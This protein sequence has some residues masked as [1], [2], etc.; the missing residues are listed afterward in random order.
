MEIP[1][2]GHY[3]SSTLMLFPRQEKA[4]DQLL[5]E[6]RHKVPATLVI[7]TSRDGQFIS[8]VGENVGKVDLVALGSLI[9]GDLA[10]SQQVARLVGAFEEFQVILREGRDSRIL[11]ADAGRSMVLFVLAPGD[12][13]AG[14]L[15]LLGLEAC[16]ALARIVESLPDELDLR[17]VKLDDKTLADQFDQALGSLWQE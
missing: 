10:A 12:V 15:R 13:P 17:T 6:L 2:E 14:W 7:L 4:I 5:A 3:V 1:P 9:A 11:V 16:R 8:A